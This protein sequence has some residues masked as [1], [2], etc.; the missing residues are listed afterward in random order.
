MGSEMTVEKQM[1][2]GF[3]KSSSLK[4]KKT[5]TKAKKQS[6][7]ADDENPY[8][9]IEV[10]N[11]AGTP[12]TEKNKNKN[13]VTNQEIITN[14]T[15][16]EPKTGTLKTKEKKDKQVVSDTPKQEKKNV[17][18]FAQDDLENYRNEF[19][20]SQ[21]LVNVIPS[22]GSNANV[23][24]ESSPKETS[25]DNDIN[26]KNKL[27]EENSIINGTID[28]DLKL[29]T[30]N[31]QSNTGKGSKNNTLKKKKE[32]KVNKVKNDEKE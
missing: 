4:R 7:V 12:K 26:E 18:K 11:S 17:K 28:N 2:N 3:E 1:T 20:K 19:A 13:E 14:G 30:T 31:D 16:S 8:E 6:K 15:E 32:T 5:P 9:K 23:T 22:K 25:I 10:N 29:A 24:K 27:E 21:G